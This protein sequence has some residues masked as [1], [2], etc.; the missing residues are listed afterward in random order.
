M[1]EVRLHHA[2]LEDD[3]DTGR[4]IL[5]GVLDQAT[6]K[7]IHLDWYQREQGFSNSHTGEIM[8]AYFAGNKVADITIGMRGQRCNSKGD[9]YVLRDKCFCID[10]GQRL[11]AAALAVEERPDL[12]IYLGAKEFLD[13]T[14][15]LVMDLF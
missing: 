9:I 1:T 14:E 15:E 3:E 5:R 11:Y 7:F 4:M 6:L 10:G 13:M 12:K 2:I 8:G